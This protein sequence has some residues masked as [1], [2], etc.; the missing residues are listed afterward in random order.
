MDNVAVNEYQDQEIWFEVYG[1]DGFRWVFVA[2]FETRAL[3]DHYRI[4]SEVCADYDRTC[5]TRRAGPFA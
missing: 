4:T 3:A 2:D 5:T 1:Y